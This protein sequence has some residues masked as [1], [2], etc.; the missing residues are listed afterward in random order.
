M[1]VVRFDFFW[2][3]TNI[4]LEADYAM[5]FHEALY[6]PGIFQ[7][8]S[9]PVSPW[10]GDSS[11]DWHSEHRWPPVVIRVRMNKNRINPNRCFV[12]DMSDKTIKILNSKP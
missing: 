2:A 3:T 12:K 5:G 7:I 4:Q 11:S 9:D 6:V 10:E 8:N 1:D